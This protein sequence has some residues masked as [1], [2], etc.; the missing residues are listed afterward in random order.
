VKSLLKN[1]ID[2]LLYS[3]LYVAAPVSAVSIIT[4]LIFDLPVNYKLVLFIY[5]STLFIYNLHRIVGLS[6]IND[7]SL[8]ARHI[9]AKKYKTFLF[10]LI[11]L[12]GSC[13]LVLALLLGTVFIAPIC[14]PAL[15]A[16]GY[17]MPIIK[18]KGKYWR[19]RDVPFAKVFLISITVSYVSVYL[20][21]YE[22]F[23]LYTQPTLFYYFL[24]RCFFIFAIT[25][26][27]DIRDL[28]FDKGSTLN[29]IPMMLGVDKA[30]Q[31]SLLCLACFS[32]IVLVL[33]SQSA[34]MSVAHLVA[35]IFAG[36]VITLCKKDSSEYY[37][38]LLVEGTMLVLFGLVWLAG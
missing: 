31:V 34:Y 11:V 33:F 25:I 14:V 29:T 28:E 5:C 7:S 17:S 19:L 16:L 6:Q 18:R 1:V 32:F 15:I 24:S 30:K 38:S 13:G 2:F 12:S 22:S 36:W 9:W 4:Y 8:S 21:L 35:A 10:F 20:P 37:Y 23:E 3:N 26:P 27:F